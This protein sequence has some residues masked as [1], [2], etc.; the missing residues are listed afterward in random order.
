MTTIDCGDCGRRFDPQ[1]WDGE[2]PCPSDDCPSHKLAYPPLVL[3][4]M[5]NPNGDGEHPVLTRALWRHAV[6]DEDTISGYW[7][8]VHHKLTEE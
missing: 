1:D 8:W 5:Y 2:T 4:E 7:D 3:D 6:V